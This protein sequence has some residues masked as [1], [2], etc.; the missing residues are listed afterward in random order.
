MAGMIRMIVDC[1]NLLFRVATAGDNK[2]GSQ[3]D[4]SGL[5]L[6]SAFQTINKYYKAHRPD[7]LVFAFEGGGNWRKTYTSSPECVRKVAYKGNRVRDSS[8]DY[9]FALMQSFKDVMHEHTSIPCIATPGMESDDTIAGY[10]QMFTGM[11]DTII[12]LSGDKD[13]IQ[14]LKHPDV[15]LINPDD[16]KPRG[17]DKK[18]G[19]QIDPLYF[20]FEKC[21]RGDKKDNVMSAYPRVRATKIKAAFEN[22]VDRI[23]LMEETWSEV[24]LVDGEAQ[25]VTYKVKDLY[26]ENKMLLDLECQPEDVKIAMYTDIERTLQNPGKYNNFHF[27]KFLGKHDLKNIAEKI[28]QYIPMLSVNQTKG[29]N[30]SND[31]NSILEI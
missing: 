20:M 3:E 23:Q 17:I 18:T 31:S 12:I 24:R 25:E 22:D 19:E 21:I 15:V 6:H 11:G 30:V 2:F 5:L 13:F 8:M 28:E 16:G 27:L 7:Q 10:V 26:E 4:R 9:I 29:K 1:P 14:L